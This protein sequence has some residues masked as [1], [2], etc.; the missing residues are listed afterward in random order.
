MQP[1]ICHVRSRDGT[2][3]AYYTMGGGPPLVMLHP[4]QVNDLLLNWAMPLRRRVMRVLAEHFTVIHLDFRGAGQSQRQ[5]KAL[6]WDALCDDVRC[7][8]DEVGVERTS[9]CA[10][11]T[12]AMVAGR[13]AST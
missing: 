2:R 1:V 3:I 5:V 4:F 11:G 10:M 9:V 8:L 12:S 13:L 6:T 7:V